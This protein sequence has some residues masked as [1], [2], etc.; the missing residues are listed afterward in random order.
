MQQIQNVVKMNPETN[1]HALIIGGEQSDR[2]FL[3]NTLSDLNVNCREANDL[4]ETAYL[5]N[6]LHF[7][8]I[9]SDTEIDSINISELIRKHNQDCK[10]IALANSKNQEDLYL[11]IKF[12]ISDILEKPIS[13]E[14]I[15]QIMSRYHKYQNDITSRF[16]NSM[17]Y[18]TFRN[19]K[20]F[21]HKMMDLYITVSGEDFDKLLLTFR[22]SDTTGL[23]DMAHKMASP[24]GQVGATRLYKLFKE[25]EKNINNNP[26]KNITDYFHDIANINYEIKKIHSILKEI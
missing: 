26:N 22:N 16:D 10:V 15:T 1:L 21:I 9:F 3:A 13:T 20:E 4:E 23:G 24:A 5:L 25:L 2:L 7:E 18:N 17:I 19:N 8:L 14:A 11:L 12:E 6:N